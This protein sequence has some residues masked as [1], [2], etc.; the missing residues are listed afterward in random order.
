V[1]GS[2]LR[3]WLP[4]L[5]DHL[6]PFGRHN[7]VAGLTVTAYLVPQVM[8]YAI[9]AG[10]SP[11]VGLWGALVA[12]PLYALLGTS[13]WLSFGPESSV[14]LMT[15][16]VIVPMVSADKVSSADA[17]AALAIAVGVVGLIASLLRLSF[18]ADLLS[19]PIL[20]GY[21]AGIAVL[22]IDSQFDRVLGT[23]TPDSDTV[24]EHLWLLTRATLWWGAIL[25]A[26]VVL[27]AL[28]FLSRTRVR[29]FGPLIALSLGVATA[30]ILNALDQPVVLL[31]D[32]PAGLPTPAIPSLPEELL[33]ELLIGAIGVLLVAYTD[34]TLTGRS[35]H[36]ASDPPL[37]PATELRALSVLNIAA[38][39]FRGMPVSTSGSRSAVARASGATSQGYSIAAAMF[40]AM[41]L[42]VA[43]PLLEVIPQAALGALVVYAAL[44]LIDV[45]DFRRLW[46]FRRSEFWLAI[47]TTAGVLIFGVLYGVLV[48]V[49]LSVLL[50]L[51]EVA[52]PHAAALGFVPG[53]AGMHDIGDFEGVKEEPGLL[54]F[55]FDSPLFFA[56][57]EFFLAQARA[58]I[59]ERS[60]GLR[61]FALQA[62]A[63]VEIDSTGV[64]VLER[65]ADEL[66]AANVR[67]V[68]VRAKSE[69]VEDLEPTGIIDR[70]GR[71]YIFPTLP[72]LVGAFRSSA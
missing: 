37:L 53:L 68:L 51:V 55:R 26:G 36:R 66:A 58:M 65:L 29:A 24:F 31:G 14:A 28:L 46:R 44:L 33:P 23:T 19:R 12:L 18:L 71:D 50:L 1:A 21:M 64:E 7:L 52:R 22:M 69:L 13:R 62:E 15:F 16:A 32:I 4:G 2:A 42:I 72:T 38:G 54:I 48:A 25:V 6:R 60:P 20:V 3:R 41:V 45:G 70:V 49:A 17:A 34:A 56:N 61:W 59:A 5:D 39:L 30:A 63:I 10:L 35:F 27:V 11:V 57:A 67:F 9:V 43:G 47:I 40:L 8:A